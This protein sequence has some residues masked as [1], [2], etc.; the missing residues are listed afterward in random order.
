[1][2]RVPIRES[3]L[4]SAL[5]ATRT[6]RTTTI[7]PY[8]TLFR[9]KST[10]SS[11]DSLGNKLVIWNVR[12]SPRP[13]R[14]WLGQCVTSWP[15]S[16]TWPDVAGKMPVI[17]LKR[18]VLPAP[19]GPMMA[20]RSPAIS[21]RFTSRTALSPPKL[22]QS[23]LS[24]RTGFLPLSA[25]GASTLPPLPSCKGAALPPTPISAS[26]AEFAWRKVAA[27]DGLLEEL[28]LAE[29]PELADVGIGLDHGVPELL[30]V[31]AEHLLLFDPLDIDVVHGVAHVVQ[32]DGTA[33]GIHLD[34]R[35]QL[36]ELLG[37]RPFAAALLQD[38][39]DHEA[40]GVG[41]LGEIRRHLA[42]LLPVLRDKRRVLRGVQGRAVLQHRDVANDLIA[43]GRQ[44]ELVVAGAAADHRLLV[45]RRRQLLGKLQRHRPD[46]QRE[47]GVGVLLYGGNERPEIDGSERWPDLLDDLAAA[48]FERP[49]ETPDG[50]VAE[51]VVGRDRY[52]ALVSLLTGPLS[53][54][55]GRLRARPAGAHEIR[56][57]V[58]L[59]LGEIIR[60][61]H[62]R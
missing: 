21:V 18:V 50:L 61:R 28:C 12:A 31:V 24:S 20:L 56:V 59:P 1:M 10:L 37:A 34:V 51:G 13:V 7:F 42:V 16:R 35:D 40:C 5:S 26:L 38:R 43:H 32:A 47:D 4:L 25:P 45:A 2:R 36:H 53:E 58:R 62:G 9:S 57:L 54:G 14:R 22:L 46:H 41:R 8:T 17:T 15:N 30:L 6:A 39:M 29:S 23:P 33:D 3:L 48:L 49:L 27:V 60:C 55:V 19:L 52:D 11:T 44:R